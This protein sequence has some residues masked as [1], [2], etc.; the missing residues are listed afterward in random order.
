ML[1]HTIHMFLAILFFGFAVGWLVQGFGPESLTKNHWE[2][3]W[4]GLTWAVF[5]MINGWP[6]W[7][8][9][10]MLLSLI[11]GASCITLAHWRKLEED[12]VYRLSLLFVLNLGITGFFPLVHF[13][14]LN[15]FT[16]I[17]SLLLLAG[18]LK[19]VE[20]LEEKTHTPTGHQYLTALCSG[21]FL[22]YVLTFAVNSIF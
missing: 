20:V 8:A 15:M 4:L 5:L 18:I 6:F 16:V 1:E 10:L 9:M 3:T 17:A 14:E 13:A 19:Y 2:K 22:I 21:V 12:T 7:V 11:L